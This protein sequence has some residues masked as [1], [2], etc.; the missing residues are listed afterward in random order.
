MFRQDKVD[1]FLLASSRDRIAQA[2]AKWRTRRHRSGAEIFTDGRIH[3]YV[4][5]RWI[6][7]AFVDHHTQSNFLRAES[8]WYLFLSNAAPAVHHDFERNLLTKS[9][10]GH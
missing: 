2:L 10:R 6:L 1:L 5:L 4:S 8:G 3:E 7:T 9:F